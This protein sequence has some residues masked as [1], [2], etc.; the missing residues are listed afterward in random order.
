ME[1]EIIDEFM[2]PVYKEQLYERHG[3]D[4]LKEIFEKKIQE[5]K[6]LK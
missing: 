6:K 5:V 2:G 4:N 1:F 3:T